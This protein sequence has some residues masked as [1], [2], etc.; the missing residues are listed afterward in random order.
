M[1]KKYYKSIVLSI[2]FFI[3]IFLFSFQSRAEIGDGAIWTGWASCESGSEGGRSAGSDGGHAF[4]LFQFD[5][6][7]ES[8]YRFLQHCLETNPETY[9]DFQYY[10]DTYHSLQEPYLS[11]SSDLSGMIN[12]WHKAYDADPDEFVRLQLDIYQQDYYAPVI[13]M[14]SQ[15]GIDLSDEERYSPVLRGTLWSISIWAG[16]TSEGVGKVISKLNSSM[17]EEEM[18]AI[19][20]SE[21]TATLKGTD[22]KYIAAFRNR[23]KSEQK[24]MALQALSKYRNGLEIPTTDSADLAQM[25]ASS[26][27]AYGIDGGVYIDY[28]QAWATK[29]P[30]LI[31]D[32]KEAGGWNSEMREWC[33]AI[34]TAGDFFEIYGIRGGGVQLDFSAGTSGG[35]MIGD[36]NV[37]AELFGI[38]D[39]GGNIP[40]VYYSQGG[41]AP[42]ANVAFGGGNIASSGCSIT[43]LAMIVS[44]L[45][46]GT[47]KDSWVFPSDIVQKIQ[48]ATGNYNFFYVGDSGQSWG[49]MSAVASYYGLTCSGISSNSIVASLA[50][51]KPVIMSC[52]P[53]EFTQKGH[54]IVLTGITEDGYIVVNDPSHPDK[55]YKKYPASY[56]AGQGKAWWSFS[57]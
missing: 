49:I 23:W 41:N 19:C 30:N 10:Y 57:N 36:V 52:K 33:E 2:L 18:L 28:I 20:Y 37:N 42:W 6:R 43:S 17:A 5:D 45:K 46:G 40:I 21:S 24:T 26:G 16:P 3:S 34:R 11:G 32:F 4:G 7:Y 50:A 53:G 9:G 56:I 15:K 44:Y 31:K 51:G 35:Y 13:S 29:Y 55:S 14:C 25:L 22:S 27:R 8:L 48:D 47:D 12:V 38:P 39:N 1:I 54:F